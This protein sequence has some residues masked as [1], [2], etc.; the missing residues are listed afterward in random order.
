MVVDGAVDVP[1]TLVRAPGFRLVSG[2][3]WSQAVPLADDRTTLWRLLRDGGAPST[4]PPTVN[5]L[6]AAYAG[7]STVVG[8]HVS[9]RLSVTV[10]RARE[11]A[12][13]AQAE[14]G[15]QVHV[16]DTGSLSVGAGLI[17]WAVHAAA[18]AARTIG[19]LVDTADR[20]PPRLHSFAL[21][22][23]VRVLRRSDR[24]GLVPRAHLASGHPLVLA[25]RGRVVPLEQPRHR[26][27]ALEALRRHLATTTGGNPEAWALGHGN[28]SDLS[29][30]SDLLSTALGKEPAFVAEI[31]PV[32][33][34][35]LGPDSLVVAALSD[36]AG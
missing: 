12:A 1:E 3:V 6:A 33:G 7:G 11:A 28:A 36:V 22:Q 9:G 8:I 27:Q 26:H 14:S 20:L 18:G 13:R 35:H 16:L 10:A 2:T 4:S 29:S 25:I 34:A 19:D 30:V 31:G 32:V 24:S 5:A 21:V 15:A 23:D 17:A